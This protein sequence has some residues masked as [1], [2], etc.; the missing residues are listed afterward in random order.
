M[1]I[2]FFSIKLPPID[3]IE[4]IIGEAAKFYE[5]VRILMDKKKARIKRA[6][7]VR[8]RIIY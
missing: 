4:I 3:K 5:R 6:R 7:R 8:R 1:I 2:V